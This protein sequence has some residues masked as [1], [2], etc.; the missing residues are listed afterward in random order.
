MSEKPQRGE[1]VWWVCVPVDEA[2]V[3]AITKTPAEQARAD[4][5]RI[6]VDIVRHVDFPYPWNGDPRKEVEIQEPAAV[7][8]E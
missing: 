4:C 7:A 6:K 1:R 8:D 5:E 3:W 2:D